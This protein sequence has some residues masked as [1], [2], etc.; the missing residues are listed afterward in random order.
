MK[1]DKQQNMLIC[2][3]IVAALGLAW[4]VS[5]DGLA[6]LAIFVAVGVF[7]VSVSPA[8]ESPAE[9]LVLTYLYR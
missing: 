7:T 9:F 8:T 5:A 2:G 1:N 4:V 6:A 3:I